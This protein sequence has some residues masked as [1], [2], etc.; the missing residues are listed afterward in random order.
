MREDQTTR[1]SWRRP[2]DGL[3]L[4]SSQTQS[5]PPFVPKQPSWLDRRNDH[6]QGCQ[7]VR[8]P[9]EI[10]CLK[11]A[12]GRKPTSRRILQRQVW[13]EAVLMTSGRIS[14]AEVPA[15]RAGEESAQGLP[16]QL[17]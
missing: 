2:Q 16:G 17:A 11:C 7:Q 1:T 3:Q 4:P 10:G 14:A 15:E 12:I 8:R 6:A 9:T 5:F 13:N